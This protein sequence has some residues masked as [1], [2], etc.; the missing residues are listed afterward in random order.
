MLNR[1]PL[2]YIGILWFGCMAGF[3]YSF[4]AVVMP[5]LEMT[6]PTAA[7]AAMQDINSAVR[8]PIFGV[9][10]FGAAAIAAALVARPALTKK[11]VHLVPAA[12]GLVY[13]I[14]TFAVTIAGNVPLNEALA[15]LDPTLEPAANA[16]TAYARE[17]TDLNHVRTVSA[18]VAMAALAWS[19]GRPGRPKD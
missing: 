11:A 9:G 13:L 3:F 5:G 14:G 10:F 2:T 15:T 4:S 6:E 18:L 8:N 1:Q 16:M 19:F 12:A 7:L 17:W